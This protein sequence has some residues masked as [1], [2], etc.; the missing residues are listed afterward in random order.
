MGIFHKAHRSLNTRLEK[1]FDG[2]SGSVV[3]SPL[4]EAHQAVSHL[5]RQQPPRKRG[6]RLPYP[7]TVPRKG[8]RIYPELS[9]TSL[10]FDYTVEMCESKSP[11]LTASQKIE[12][13]GQS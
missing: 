4:N 10:H 3:R 1:P 11:C 7:T 8:G 9:Q 12:G 5:P 13:L 2:Q 6:D